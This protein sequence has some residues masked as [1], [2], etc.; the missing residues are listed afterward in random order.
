MSFPAMTGNKSGASL[1]DQAEMTGPF[2]YK[3]ESLIAF[4][5]LVCPTWPAVQE[6]KPLQIAHFAQNPP[7]EIATAAWCRGELVAWVSCQRVAF[8]MA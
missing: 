3:N 2:R 7:I 8:R 6:N 5:P 4:G 1:I